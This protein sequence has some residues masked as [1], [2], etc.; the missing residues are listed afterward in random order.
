M[1]YPSWDLCV[2]PLSRDHP[3]AHGCELLQPHAEYH[4]SEGLIPSCKS[5][6]S[7]P[8]TYFSEFSSGWCRLWS[9]GAGNRT[10]E[11]GLSRWP[12]CHLAI[13]PWAHLSAH[14]HDLP[15]MVKRDMWVKLVEGQWPCHPPAASP[16]RSHLSKNTG[17]RPASRGGSPTS[18]PHQ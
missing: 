1:L 4:P 2:Q 9:H 10:L 14:H 18:R 11:L 6:L 5:L 15:L 12:K 7:E 13:D 8:T 17:A 3:L 16:E